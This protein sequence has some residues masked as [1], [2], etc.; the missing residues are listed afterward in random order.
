M[1]IYTLVPLKR[2]DKCKTRLSAVLTQ[3][4]RRDL[5]LY[6]LRDVLEAVRKSKAESIGIVAHDN[7]VESVAAEFGANFIYD[8]GVQ[9]LN[10]T[11]RRMSMRIKA[12]GFDA[13]FVVLADVPRIHP[14]DV[15]SMF[16]SLKMPNSMVISPSI[17]NGTNALLLSPPDSIDVRYGK[18][19]FYTHIER[20]KARGLGYWIYR[21][22]S[23]S[24]DVDTPKDLLSLLRSSYDCHSRRF[25]ESRELKNRL[26]LSR[27][28]A[29]P[30]IRP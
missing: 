2:L 13:M 15:N 7:D 6:M 24:A 27:M 17:E 8:D 28:R 14:S 3:E 11:V 21:S 25:L 18:N 4:E 5:S 1:R 16:D 10:E 20:V 26:T 22:E 23:T 12:L 29:Q 9:G 19:S 30:S